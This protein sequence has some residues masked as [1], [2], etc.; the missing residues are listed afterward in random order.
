MAPMPSFITESAAV[1]SAAS[2]PCRPRLPILAVDAAARVGCGDEDLL[3][4]RGPDQVCRF[5]FLFV[6]NAQHIHLNKSRFT[7][8]PHA[9]ATTT[10]A[11]ATAK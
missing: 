4:S 7:C 6:L 9:E 10:Y 8:S 2:S 11:M 5:V 3:A 1:T